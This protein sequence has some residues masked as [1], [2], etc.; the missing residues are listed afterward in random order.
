M[1]KFTAIHVIFEFLYTVNFIVEIVQNPLLVVQ[2]FMF[3]ILYNPNRGDY[4][5]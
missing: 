3:Y 2:R 1:S 4:C 5:I